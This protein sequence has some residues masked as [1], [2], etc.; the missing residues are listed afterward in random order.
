LARPQTDTIEQREGRE[1]H[2]NGAPTGNHIQTDTIT[3]HLSG[4][5]HWTTTWARWVLLSFSDIVIGEVF[6]ENVTMQETITLNTQEQKRAMVLNRILEGQLSTAEA[7]PLL[8]LSKRQ[9][10][11]LL[12]AYRKE[13]VAALVHGNRGRQPI[14]RLSEDT[15]QQILTLAQTS[16]AGA[17]QQH[18]RDLLE[19]RDGIVVSRSTVRR[20]VQQDQRIRKQP[21]HRRR[22]KRYRAGGIDQGNPRNRA[23]CAGRGA[24]PADTRTVGRVVPLRY[25]CDIYGRIGDRA[26]LVPRRLSAWRASVS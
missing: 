24:F 16:Y 20:I 6:S 2:L 26:C 14:H 12:A 3:G 4:H 1:R 5:N 7:A 9:V 17:N 25:G 21:Q 18:L 13:G 23:T 8:K 19:E 22:R 15:R 11:R 10:Q